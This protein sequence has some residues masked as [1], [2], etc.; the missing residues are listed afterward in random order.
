MDERTYGR[1]Y[2]HIDSVNKE[3]YVCHSDSRRP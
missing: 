1:P 2:A 3:N